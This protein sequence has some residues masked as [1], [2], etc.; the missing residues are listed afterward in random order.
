MR[1]LREAGIST[2][3]AREAT[4]ALA[5][6]AVNDFDIIVLDVMLGGDRDGLDICRS[7]RR[8]GVL[9]RVLMLTA[10]DAV[11]DRVAGLEAGA[12]DYLVKPFAFEELLARLRALSRRP[13]A[14]V[15]T[16]QECGGLA[17]D[18][19]SRKVT[20]EGQSIDV[21]RKEFDILELLMTNRGQV[22]T[23]EQ[24]HDHVWSYDVLH[25]SNLV[26][27][28]VGRLRR[29]LDRSAVRAEIA[30]VRGLGYRLEPRG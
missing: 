27:V 15:S 9:S 29:K 17:V 6:A 26:E 19:A 22:V 8:D 11:A 18:T 16:A 24:I 21:T 5:A 7:L 25:D 30:T 3:V 23:K 28:Y 4:E 12:D 20:A 14:A 2:T 13:A 1:G 10:R